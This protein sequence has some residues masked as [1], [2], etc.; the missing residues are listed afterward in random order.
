MTTSDRFKCRHCD[1]TTPKWTTTKD[2][3][4]KSGWA[5]LESHLEIK[6]GIEADLSLTED[7]TND[8]K[9]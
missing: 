8:R 7:Q 6:H 2:G 4:K 1:W 5:R 9:V 3:R